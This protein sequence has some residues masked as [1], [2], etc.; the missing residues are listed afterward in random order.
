MKKHLSTVILVLIFIVGLSVV[1]Y[2][3]ISNYINTLHQSRVV[4]A[5]NETVADME[6]KEKEEIYNQAADYNKRLA[7]SGSEGF[8]NPGTV[9][10]YEDTLDITGTGIMGY[11][12]IPRINIE[13]P[14]Y[15]GTSQGVLQVAIGHLEGTSLPVGG[16]STHC[17]LSGHRGLPSA[18]LFTH[19][20]KLE[21]GDTFTI[22]VMDTV[23][24]YEVDKISIVLPEEVEQLLIKDG[25]DYCTL[26]TCTPYGIN[27]HRLLVRGKRVANEND[28]KDLRVTADAYTI[29]TTIVTPIV[30]IPLF[31]L[32][33]IGLIVHTSRK[34]KEKKRRQEKIEEFINE[35]K[36]S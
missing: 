4:A 14:I 35:K 7:E 5:Y 1:L 17:V 31:I 32:L 26:M 3:S 33:L 21:V 25:K 6:D 27:T 34:N 15:H 2:P 22:T 36:D 13:L 11:L 12:T 8:F 16:A 19:L 23:L 30:A 10:G 24:T 29:D 20:D 28:E 18:D 9:S